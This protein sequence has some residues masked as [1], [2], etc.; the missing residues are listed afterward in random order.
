MSMES[1]VRDLLQVLEPSHLVVI[2]ESDGCGAKIKVEIV[3]EHFNGK[4]TLNCHRLVQEKLGDT[5][6]EIHAITIQAY[7]PEKFA[8]RQS[9]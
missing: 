1:R 5:L 7:T 3:S 2:D 9:S 4:S 6:K 8:A